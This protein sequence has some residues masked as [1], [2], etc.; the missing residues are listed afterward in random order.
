MADEQT[1][2][3][4]T[5]VGTVRVPTSEAVVR[6]RVQSRQP[7]PGAAL[8]EAGEVVLRAL[9]TLRAVGLHDG[10]VRTEAVSVAPHQVWVDEAEQVHGYDAA[11]SLHVRV[12]DLGLLDRL[13]EELVDAC[14]TA[15]VIEDVALSGEPTDAALAEAR[16]E[17]VERAH[18]KAADY[19]RL[20]GRTLGRAQSVVEVTGM[21]RPPSPRGRAMFAEAASAMPIAQ[22]QDSSSVTVEVHWSFE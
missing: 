17:A 3:T 4:V 19:A 21:H 7:Q 20:T 22:G 5:G 14:G 1:G 9:E 12:A 16:H 13:L 2:V 6:L 8:R 10:D 18:T 15:L 11:Q